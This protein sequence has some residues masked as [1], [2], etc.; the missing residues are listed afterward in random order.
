MGGGGVESGIPLLVSLKGRIVALGAIFQ[1]D[2]TLSVC[3]EDI[4]II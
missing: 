1:E 2:M 3:N 4:T